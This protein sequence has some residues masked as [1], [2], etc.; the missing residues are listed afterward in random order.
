M[1]KIDHKINIPGYRIIRKIGEGGM[2]VVYL[3]FQQSLKREVALKAMRPIITDEESVIRR[4]E[5]EAEIIA[6]LYHPNIVNIYEVGHVDEDV[7]FYSMPYL[8]HG[9]LTSVA[10]QNDD[11]LK[12]MLA[13]ICDGLAYAHTQGVVH[14]DIKPEN[15]L[16]DQFGNV[17]I[18]DF[19]IAL[20]TGSRRFTKDSKVLG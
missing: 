4:F 17:Q 6:K 11:E 2:S 7:L 19:G 18:A 8:Q 20:S 5:Q 12:Q 13:G 15:I 9:D 1:T 3:A 16:F 10:Y 14:R